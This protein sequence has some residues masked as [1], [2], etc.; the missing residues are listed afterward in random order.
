MTFDRSLVGL[1]AK[2]FEMEVERGK[3]REFALATRA[4]HPQYLED[5]RPYAPPTFLASA[6][7]WEEPE[8]SPFHAIEYDLA[9][10][11]HAEQ[12]FVFPAGPPR[13]GT[14]LR[15]QARVE[16]VYE[17]EGRR[18]GQLSFIVVVTDFTDPSGTVV[19]QSR[20]TIVQT[21]KPP[22]EDA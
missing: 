16:D 13:A 12:E 14:P 19:A 11:L 18:G 2:P 1:Q 5:R 20:M 9:R 22:S 17:R 10:V 7:F 15:A 6:A 4:T 21:E 8:N 3:I